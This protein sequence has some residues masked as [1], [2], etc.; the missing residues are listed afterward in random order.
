MSSIFLLYWLKR[1]H[2]NQ[3]CTV[4][5]S[6]FSKLPHSKTRNGPGLFSGCVYINNC[7][8]CYHN[9]RVVVTGSSE[10]QFIKNNLKYLKIRGLQS[11]N[12]N[13]IS[14]LKDNHEYEIIQKS[15]HVCRKRFFSSFSIV[16]DR[17]STYYA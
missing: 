11:Q 6:G 12:S 7:Y 3:W 1:S 2:E 10:S 17:T 16:L 9:T 13:L 14:K 8:Q 4:S 5:V 15:I